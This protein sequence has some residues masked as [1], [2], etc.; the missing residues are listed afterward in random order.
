M[1]PATAGKARQVDP[2]DKALVIA[3]LRMVLDE[4]GTPFEVSVMTMNRRAR[5]L[6]YQFA[7]MRLRLLVS[8][9]RG[10]SPQGR[11]GSSVTDGPRC[12][13][14]GRGDVMGEVQA[15]AHFVDVANGCETGALSAF[16]SIGPA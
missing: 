8:I 12:G 15:N 3:L 7:T 9:A 13:W 10:E 2:P 6:R 16:V 5:H 11:L 14:Q 1:R 4:D